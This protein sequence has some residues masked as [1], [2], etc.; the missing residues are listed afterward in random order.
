MEM[1]NSGDI[2][3]GDLEKQ[4]GDEPLV[5]KIVSKAYGAPQKMHV[6]GCK[7]CQAARLLAMS[8]GLALG[9][10]GRALICAAMKEKGLSLPYVSFTEGCN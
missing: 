3:P 1:A 2:L 7:V 9:L 4:P 8:P 5:F 10:P 6:G